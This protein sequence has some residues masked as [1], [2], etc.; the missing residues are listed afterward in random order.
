MLSMFILAVSLVIVSPDAADAAAAA[1]DSQRIAEHVRVLASDKFTGRF[2]GSEGEER[3]VQYIAGHFAALGLAPVQGDEY[4]QPVGLL[5]TRPSD[6]P[7]LTFPGAADPPA[8]RHSVD[9]TLDSPQEVE[10]VELDSIELVFVGYGIEAP[11]YRWSDLEGADL[12]GQTVMFLWG[13]PGSW[14]GDE[15][16]FAG[17]D[18]L[19]QEVGFATGHS[20]A[21]SETATTGTIGGLWIRSFTMVVDYMHRRIAFVEPRE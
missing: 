13:D 14:G 10:G 17:R 1:L 8:L 21:F 12:R 16:L 20:G 11:E 6:I 5:G 19:D 7:R 15:E 3:T 4:F 2:P 18:F 9:F